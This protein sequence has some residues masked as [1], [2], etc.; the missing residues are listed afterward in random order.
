METTI[1]QNLRQ[2]LSRLTAGQ[3]DIRVGATT[4]RMLMQQLPPLN[5]LPDPPLNERQLFL[6]GQLSIVLDI[7]AAQQRRPVLVRWFE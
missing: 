6:L 5:D 4:V 1:I 7:L 3:M 2:R